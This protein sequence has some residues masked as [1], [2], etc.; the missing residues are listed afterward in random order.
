[1]VV[2]ECLSQDL[3]WLM[4]KPSPGS[5]EQVHVSRTHVL[6]FLYTKL[7]ILYYAHFWAFVRRRPSD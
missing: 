3:W 7:F 6:A 2:E 4:F 1:M 5:K